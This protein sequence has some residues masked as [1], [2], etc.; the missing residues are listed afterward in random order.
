MTI[1]P[2]RPS[3]AESCP[4]LSVLSHSPPA[5]CCSTGLEPPRDATPCASQ[6]L[7]VHCSATAHGKQR[8]PFRKDSIPLRSKAATLHTLIPS[9][10]RA[11]SPAYSTKK[12]S[13]RRARD[14]KVSLCAGPM[15]GRFK[16]HLSISLLVFVINLPKE[17]AETLRL[18]ARPSG[19]RWRRPHGPLIIGC[20]ENIF[21]ELTTKGRVF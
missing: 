21:L 12:G 5:L 8:I 4:P 1:S 10:A 2:G 3:L 11:H 6:H 17:I 18:W 9:L 20:T 13:F 7:S 16:N 15:E 19:Q 14:S